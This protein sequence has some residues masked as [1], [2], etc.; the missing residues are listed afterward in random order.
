MPGQPV[1]V[2]QRGNNRGQVFFT[3]KDGAYYL[4]WLTEAARKFGVSIHAYVLMT[5]HLHLLVTPATMEALGRTMLT[6]GTRFTRY[7][8][9][10]QNRSGTLWEG[11]YRSSLI[12]TDA[13]LLACMRYIELNP[14]RAG[15]AKEPGA[16]RWSSYKHNAL[17]RPDA[18]LTPHAL[19]TALGPTDEARA[20]AYRDLVTTPLS[21]SVLENIRNATNWGA[22]MGDTVT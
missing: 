7:I 16:F 3:P 9:A 21:A 4:E 19:Y 5:N 14:V 8:N 12:T 2:I 20:A 18:A 11:R 17:M 1:H 15:L 6:V 10:T 13:Y 22:D